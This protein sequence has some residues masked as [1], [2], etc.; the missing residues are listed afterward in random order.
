[1]SATAGPIQIYQAAEPVAVY[2]LRDPRTGHVRYVGKAVDPARRLQQHLSAF[3]LSYYRSRKNSW[4]KNLLD[5]GGRPELEIVETV[6]PEQANDAEC[7]WI[8][9]YHGLGAPLTNGTAGG[10]GGAVTDPEARARI[11]AAHRGAKRSAGTRKKMSVVHRERCSDPKERARL[12]AISNGKPPVHH[13]EKNPRTKLSDAQVRQLRELAAAGEDLRAL[14]AEY[15]ITAA[16]VTQL[17]CGQFRRAAGGPIR[18]AKPRSK[19]TARNVAEIHRLAAD[20]VAQ[21][22]I[23][24]RFD[25]HPSHISRT[26]SGQRRR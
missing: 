24:R 8:A 10:D 4:L 15:G 7:K 16:S 19:L 20:G 9:Y 13:G 5:A 6:A 12:K 21:T 11:S 18:E 2:L 3:Q 25:V 1:M 14:A 23:A 17:V 26:L 22:E